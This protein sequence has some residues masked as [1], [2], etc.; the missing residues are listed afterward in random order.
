MSCGEWP[1]EAPAEEMAE[2]E[3]SMK[4]FDH[5]A[6][7]FREE[8]AGRGEFVPYGDATGGGGGLVGG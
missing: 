3:G 8:Y 2:D 1:V 7:S 6:P 5:D 4:K